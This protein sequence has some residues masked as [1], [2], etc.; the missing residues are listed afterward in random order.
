MFLEKNDSTMMFVL[1]INSVLASLLK[2]NAL[3][4]HSIYGIEETTSFKKTSIILGGIKEKQLRCENSLY[5][6]FIVVRGIT[7]PLIPIT[8]V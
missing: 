4:M 5:R 8:R 1:S 2:W 6:L 3:F 7:T